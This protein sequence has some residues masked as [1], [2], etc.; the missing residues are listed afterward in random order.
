MNTKTSLVLMLAAVLLTGCKDNNKQ[1]QTPP[2]PVKTMKVEA[3]PG[4]GGQAFPGT[5]EETTGSVLSF[6]VGGTLKSVSVS[7]GTKVSKGQLIA[8]VDDA[9]LRNAHDIA[10]TTLR[11]AQDAYGRMKQLHDAGSLPEIQWVEVQSKLEQAQAAER[12]AK[13]SLHDSRLYAPFSGIISEKNAESGQNVLPGMP[14]VKLVKT[15]QV[16]VKVAVPENDIPNIKVG[17]QTVVTVQA[18][19]GK[20]FTGQI[21][22]K[23]VTANPVTRSYEVKALLSNTTGELLPGMVCD[24][25]IASGKDTGT[26]IILPARIIQLDKNNRQFV[27]TVQ[28]GKAHK[29]MIETGEVTDRGIVVTS[30]LSVGDEVITEGQQKVSEESKIIKK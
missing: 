2:L 27:W 19:G 16:K 29:C 1:L 11:Q 28:N 24:A 3:T 26:T 8:V 4:P 6:A 14:I 21:V 30:G 5:I 10:A 18:L 25:S 20:T 13:K 9:T 15:Q 22:E 12:I 23:G 7:T 17:Q